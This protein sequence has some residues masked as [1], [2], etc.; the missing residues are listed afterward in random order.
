MTTETTTQ[1][2]P[3]GE[4]DDAVERLVED[5]RSAKAAAI[6]LAGASEMEKRY[7]NQV[8]AML[9]T[10]ELDLG[11]AKAALRARLAEHPGAVDESMTNVVDATHAWV[12]EMRVQSH[13]ARMEAADEA[14]EID[15]RIE[16]TASEARRAAGRISETVGDDLEEMRALALYGIGDVREALDDALM[17]IRQSW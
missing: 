1:V 16:H 6:V 10:V 7:G 14:E 9:A 11:I 8:S 12:D 5:A 2:D 4:L 17:A 15:R 13:L 3:R